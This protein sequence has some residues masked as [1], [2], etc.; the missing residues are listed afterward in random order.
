MTANPVLVEQWRGN[1]V[2]SAHRGAA[3]VVDV[4]GRVIRQIGNVDQP[5]LVNSAL[6]LAQ[7]LPFI[8]TGAADR[9]QCS[10]AEITLAAASQIGQEFQRIVLKA[11]LA[12]LGLD[13]SALQC[14]ITEP[15]DRGTCNALIKRGQK[16]GVF[17]NNNAG[18]HIAILATALHL[19]E[20]TATYLDPDHPAQ[21]RIRQAVAQVSGQPSVEAGPVD[22]CSMPSVPISLRRQATATNRI[23]TATDLDAANTAAAIRLIAAIRAE[24]TF[25]VGPERLSTAICQCTKGRIIVKGGN[26]GAYTAVDTARGHGYALKIDDGAG[27]AADMAMIRLLS[28]DG[29]LASN[30][31]E[32]L[33]RFAKSAILGYP[34]TAIGSIV[35]TF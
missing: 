8:A 22:R 3:V 5:V 35:P 9:W 15:Y 6:K 32:H 25:L 21:I 31:I 20:P 34:G 23:G 17:H 7:A 29:S 16:P 13:R 10:N 30:E 14:G 28:A 4:D 18:K 26:E 2:E 24:P 19:G 12:R 1:Y 11:W 33:T 27:R